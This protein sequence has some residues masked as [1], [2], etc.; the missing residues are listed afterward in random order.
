MASCLTSRARCRLGLP[1]RPRR[2]NWDAFHESPLR[3]GPLGF[4]GFGV[5]VRPWFWLKKPAPFTNFVK[6]VAPGRGELDMVLAVRPARPARALAWIG[7]EFRV[8]H[9][10]AVQGCGF[11]SPTICLSPGST[12]LPRGTRMCLIPKRSP[13]AGGRPLLF[14]SGTDR[15]SIFLL[16][17]LK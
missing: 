13:D 2:N 1:R 12:R 14:Q 5:C 15:L 4:R 3:R 10:C 6:D 8:P 7:F 17:E 9:P 16:R 11:S